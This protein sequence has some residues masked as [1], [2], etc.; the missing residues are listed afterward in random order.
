MKVTRVSV[1]NFLSYKQAAAEFDSG[2]NIITGE[3]ASGKTNLV[4]A[5][6]FASIGRS[7]RHTRE[8]EIINWD[9][10][11]GA[12]ITVKLEKKFSKHEIDIYIDNSGGKRILIDGQPIQ[13]MGELMGVLNIVF[14]SPSELTL[15]KGSPQDRRRFLDISLSQ[16]SRMYFYALQRYFGLLAQRNKILKQY[17]LS[18]TLADMLELT[19]REMAKV[20]AIIINERNKH[21]IALADYAN[22]SHKK[23]T[24][25][26]ENLQITYETEN[27]NFDDLENDIYKLFKVAYN[28]DVKQEYTTTG[29]HRDDV[30][31][32]A[33]DIDLRKFG[34]Q[35]QQRTSVLSLKLA[36]I[37]LFKK[38]TSETPV[39]ILDDVLSELDESRRN[40]L[41]SSLVGIQT[42][43]TCTEFS[44]E[45]FINCRAFQIKDQ[46][47]LIQDI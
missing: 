23:L 44:K 13:K 9:S 28:D 11:I 38:R 5:I 45:N 33:N 27:L 31:I 40:A 36:E 6:F 29:P 8:R 25:G 34:S 47:I 41:L 18:S 21:I 22:A 43:I 16:Q 17:K 42:L 19:D 12:R 39:L 1:S 35:G 24:D 26:K 4:D 15:I 30:K 7:S 2:I 20:A 10:N 3:N 14:F 46:K 37:E 32:T